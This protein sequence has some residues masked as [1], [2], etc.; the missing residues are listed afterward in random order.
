MCYFDREQDFFYYGGMGGG[1]IVPKINL[2]ELDVNNYRELYVFNSLDFEIPMKQMKN[3]DIHIL[4]SESC[5]IEYSIEYF[6]K[7]LFVKLS[8]TKLSIYVT[9][10]NF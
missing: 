4:P 1:S 10:K 6:Y 5:Q 3:I 7:V 8:E 2:V 9:Q